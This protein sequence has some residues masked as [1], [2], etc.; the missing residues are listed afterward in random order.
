MLTLAGVRGADAGFALVM[1]ALGSALVLNVLLWVTLLVSIPAA[2]FRPIYV[3]MAVIGLLVIAAFAGTIFALMRG[4]D[5]AERFVRAVGSRVHFLDEDR[6]AEFVQRLAGR[7]RELLAD[8][9]LVRRLAVWATL[10]WLL[11]AGAL[12]VFLRAFGPSVRLDA[13][14]VAFCVANISATIPIT[15]GGL[16]V[17]D[18]TLVAML[19]LFGYGGAAGLAVPMYRLAQ[20]WMPIP[21]GAMSYITLRTGPW[22]IDKERAL[23]RLREETQEVVRT[24]ETVYEW[25]EKYGRRV[26]PTEVE[27]ELEPPSDA[28][29]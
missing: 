11:D 10:N 27:A 2:G 13:L 3:T 16:G 25:A 1:S 20:Y 19:A 24:G 12:W 9:P 8:Q 6:L 15:P 18:A 14:I 28:G 21:L 26:R 23:R 5:R 4:Q 22:R 29:P 17:L 7:V